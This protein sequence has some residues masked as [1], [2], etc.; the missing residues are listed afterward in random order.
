MLELGLPVPSWMDPAA[1]KSPAAGSAGQGALD[2]ATA[3]AGRPHSRRELIDMAMAEDR[4]TNGHY[5]NG[6]G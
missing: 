1:G 4:R 3:A 5:L 6:G 2:G